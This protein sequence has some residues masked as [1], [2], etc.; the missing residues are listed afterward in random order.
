MEIST[1]VIGLFFTGAVGLRIWAIRVYA[2][3]YD[4]LPK[5]KQDDMIRRAMPRGY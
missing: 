2:N 1:L 3:F 4:S 5:E